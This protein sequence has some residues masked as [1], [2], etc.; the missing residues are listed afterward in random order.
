MMN[1]YSCIANSYDALYG[2][3]QLK[4]IKI[5]LQHKLIK[6]TESILDVGCGT[7]VYADFF[8]NYMGIDSAKKMLKDS[9]CVHGC[10]EHLPFPD[11]SFDVVISITAIHNFKDIDQAL[12][13][14]KRVMKRKVIISLLK[15]SS[16][17]I[18]IKEKI[19]NCF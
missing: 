11:K 13:E 15:R 6:K 10:A 16:K 3:E 8:K 9:R 19:K 1:Y 17:Y 12:K 2:E 5:I 4:K 7:A 18:T 14:I